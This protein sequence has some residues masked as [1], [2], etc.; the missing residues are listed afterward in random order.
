MNLKISKTTAVSRPALAAFR[1]G[2]A[3]LGNFAMT[4]VN[5][6]HDARI[7]NTYDTARMPTDTPGRSSALNHSRIF[8][9]SPL[10]DNAER[11]NVRT[12]ARNSPASAPRSSGVQ[13][14]AT[15]SHLTRSMPSPMSSYMTIVR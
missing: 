9:V 10:L 2:N 15:R 13:R 4:Q 8:S 3:T 11:E 14:G 6:N 5:S 7:D 1:S 12:I